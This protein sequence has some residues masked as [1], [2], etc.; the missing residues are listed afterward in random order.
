MAGIVVAI[1]M[2]LISVLVHFE[3]LII[4]ER[5][6][7]R[8]KSF[9]LSL[10]GAWFGLLL[11]HVLE[12]WLYAAAYWACDRLGVGTL[13]GMVNS[14]DYAYF[15]AVVYTTLGFGDILPDEGLRMLAG[16]EAL[17]GLCLIAWSATITY[18][19]TQLILKRRSESR[20]DTY[21]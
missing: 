10:L 5:V 16:S 20:A 9:R 11:A 4:V 13:R 17:V 18:T 21:R 19:H 7:E 15:S 14:L 1:L 2:A 12:I 8:I 3:A 6:R